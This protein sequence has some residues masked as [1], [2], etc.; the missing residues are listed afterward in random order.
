MKRKLIIALA[1]LLIIGGGIQLVS[2]MDL[3][4]GTLKQYLPLS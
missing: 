4:T 1:A 2:S 3:L